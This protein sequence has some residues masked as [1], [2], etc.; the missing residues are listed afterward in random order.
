MRSASLPKQYRAFRRIRSRTI[1][2]AIY[3]GLMLAIVLL[4]TF[5]SGWALGALLCTYGIHQWAQSQA[6]FFAYNYQITN[7]LTTAIVLWALACK[8]CRGEQPFGNYPRVGR[9]VMGLLL[10]SLASILW[11]IFRPGSISQWGGRYHTIIVFVGLAPLLIT[12][13]RDLRDMCMGILTIGT[14]CLSLLWFQAHWAGR[15]VHLAQAVY[16]YGQR[17]DQTNAL[18]IAE[19]GGYVAMIG[20]LLNFHGIGRFWQVMRR[21]AVV[22]GL[23]I[24]IRSGSRG[25]T[26]AAVAVGVVSLPI[27]R[28]L[29]SAKGFLATGLGLVLLIYI[30]W[31]AYETFGG[32]QRWA[33]EGMLKDFAGGRLVPSGI[34]LDHWIKANPFHW[35]FGLGTSASFDPNIAGFYPHMVPAEVLGELGIFGEALFLGIFWIS[36]R[37]IRR[38]YGVMRHDPTQRGVL[39][40][41]GALIAYDA[42]LSCKAGS[43][44]GNATLLALPIMLGRLDVSIFGRPA[45]QPLPLENLHWSPS[46]YSDQ[47]AA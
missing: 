19:L 36:F 18:A 17:V 4:A 23:V 37:S 47:P 38:L 35:V 3:I 20:L 34:L 30:A 26:I 10:F 6:A 41:V 13:G 44:L 24:C 1:T 28:Q 7:Y 2:F 16:V 40:C 27:S 42:I 15:G 14:V 32:G 22:I 5:R 8:L 45:A 39:A 29:R 43:L 9:V 25:P 12:S 33:A 31:F 21:V 46:V 11:S